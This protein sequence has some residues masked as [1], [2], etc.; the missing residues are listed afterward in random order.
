M[1]TSRSKSD[2]QI[3]LDN[4]IQPYE[5]TNFVDDSDINELKN[6]YSNATNKIYKNTGPITSKIEHYDSG[7]RLKIKNK[8]HSLYPNAEI[9]H[10]MF[11]DV[12]VPHI[13]HNDD[14]YDYPLTYV[15]FNIPV[16]IEGFTD[17]YPELMFFDQ[18]YLD[19]P[20]K[21]FNKEE[22]I[23][24]HYN[25]CIYEYSKVLNK[26][27]EGIDPV[28][29]KKISHLKDTWLEGLSINSAFKWKPGNSIVFNPCRLHCASDFRLFGIKRKLGI[30]IFTK[31]K[32]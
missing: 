4:L 16:F 2:K 22:H 24:T 29:R 9:Y 12:T 26:T 18:L 21:L 17:N 5:I 7:V 14:G 27:N 19:G 31:L 28:Y 13:I 32:L 23:E 1:N 11:F 20:V 15:A 25:Q 3:I 8:I 30:S 10:G 6:I